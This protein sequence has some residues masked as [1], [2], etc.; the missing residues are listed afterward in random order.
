MECSICYDDFSENDVVK[1]CNGKHIFCK[2]CFEDWKKECNNKNRDTHCPLCKTFIQKMELPSGKM[3]NYWNHSFYKKEE[4]YISPKTYKRDGLYQMWY[5]NGKLWKSYNYQDGLLHGKCKTWYQNGLVETEFTCFQN[6]K[7]GIYTLWNL[8][9]YK[10][11]EISYKKNMFDGISRKWYHNGKIMY[12]HNFKNNM[13]DGMSISWYPNGNI[14]YI[15][16]YTENVLSKYCVLKKYIGTNVIECDFDK[17]YIH[18]YEYK[19]NQNNK[20]TKKINF[21]DNEKKIYQNM[22]FDIQVTL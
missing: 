13:F 2:K 10:E 22:I 18:F 8:Y 4:Y 7:D 15:L 16:H 17:K 14:K 1:H 11:I 6:K 9:G 20:I 19:S 12:E 5:P 3:I 21:N